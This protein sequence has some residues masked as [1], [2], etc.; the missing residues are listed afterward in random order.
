MV[1]QNRPDISIDSYVLDT[2]AIVYAHLAIAL[3]LR[4]ERLEMGH[5]ERFWELLKDALIVMKMPRTSSVSLWS[6][7]A[8]TLTLTIETSMKLL[9]VLVYSY[10][11][12]KNYD[13]GEYDQ[14][15]QCLSMA[16]TQSEL[17]D[18]NINEA[19][20][21]DWQWPSM[22]EWTGNQ[23]GNDPAIECF[24]V[25]YHLVGLIVPMQ[26]AVNAFE[27]IWRE[28]S[29]STNWETLSSYCERFM[30]FCNRDYVPD[31]NPDEY[32]I[33]SVFIAGSLDAD[34]FWG[35]AKELASQ[36]ISPSELIEFLEQGRK[37]ESETRLRLYF[38]RDTWDNLPEKARAALISA[39]REYEN[40]W[41][42]RPI[43][44]DHLR[45]AA[46][47]IIVEAL[48][49]PYQEYRRNKATNGEL[50]NLADLKRVFE[51]DR[52]EPDRAAHMMRDLIQ[53]PHFEEFLN[54]VTEDTRFVKR[55]PNKL[56][57]LNEW[58]NR[59]SHEHHWGYKGF[60]GQ[61][62]ETYAE[63]LGIGRNGILPRL[64]RLR[65]M[66]GVNSRG[67]TS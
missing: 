39:D 11:F 6:N 10:L 3:A 9:E 49:Q 24:G 16:I 29:S 45:H 22:L 41:G 32:H 52:S 58:A 56:R 65:S 2:Q 44:F 5:T 31:N 42:R 26:N 27:G 15:L 57:D 7:S 53:E 60:E 35:M 54:T 40:G 66:T 51:D 36:R 17:C 25:G 12:H 48:W 61:I 67:R 50:K 59:V 64:M 30:T 13:D 8:P 37:K 1:K 20:D 34:Q 23:S 14:A 55:L 4:L 43:I 62:R 63:F 21:V 33:Y 28:N 19:L 38:F 18:H 47:A 46:R